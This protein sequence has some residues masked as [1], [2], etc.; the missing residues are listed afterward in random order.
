MFATSSP[1]RNGV[2]FS[3]ITINRSQSYIDSREVKIVVEKLGSRKPV[4]MSDL[5]RSALL[6]SVTRNDGKS[7]F[8]FSQKKNEFKEK[9][10]QKN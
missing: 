1:R 4:S 3:A 8:N 10:K 7:T 2:A 9:L 5:N 6:N